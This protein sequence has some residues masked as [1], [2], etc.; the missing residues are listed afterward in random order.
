MISY[1]VLAGVVVSLIPAVGLFFTCKS[2]HDKLHSFFTR[3]QDVEKYATKLH[4]GAFSIA[5]LFAAVCLGV[6]SAPWF[7]PFP[8]VRVVFGVLWIAFFYV[9]LMHILSRFNDDKKSAAK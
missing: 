5:V 9:G 3:H 2:I 4:M 6:F 7:Y 1:I 8:Y